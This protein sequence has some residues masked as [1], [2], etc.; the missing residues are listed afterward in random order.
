MVSINMELLTGIDAKDFS[1]LALKNHLQPI[2]LFLTKMENL[3]THLNQEQ[4]FIGKRFIF[5][6]YRE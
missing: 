1:N 4:I 2:D 6:K 5:Y 3:A